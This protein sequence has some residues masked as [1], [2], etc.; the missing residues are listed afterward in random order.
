[1]GV[2]SEHL[3][4]GRNGRNEMAIRHR[5]DR[6]RVD[7]PFEN[8]FP[9]GSSIDASKEALAG[10]YDQGRVRVRRGRKRLDSACVRKLE[11][12]PAFPTV[13]APSEFSR[14]ADP[15]ACPTFGVEEKVFGV[16][17]WRS[18]A[19]PGES[20][21]VAEEETL[22]IGQVNLLRRSWIHCK[23]TC[24][25]RRWR[26]KPRPCCPTVVTPPVAAPMSVEPFG[27]GG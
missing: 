4:G 7:S 2:F 21:V 19:T 16:E 18:D 9:T 14:G 13:V 5:I 12:K 23:H 8:T 22:G 10:N 15:E 6:D 25:P 11:T 26:R 3:C 1:M 24:P 27:V 20:V 17:A